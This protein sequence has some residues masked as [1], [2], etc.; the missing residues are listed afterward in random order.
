M[1][2]ESVI[3]NKYLIG[4]AWALA[5]SGLYLTSLHSYLLFHSLAEIFSIVVACAIFM[6]AWNSRKF[7]DNNYL[8]FIGI[9]YL[10]VGGLDLIHT[11]AYKG[12]NVLPGYGAN[13]PTQLWVATRYI[14]SLSLLIA[15][16]F[17][18]RKLRP[19][20]I[21]TGYSLVT[22][23]V[24]GTIFYWRIFPDCFIEGV[25][26]TPFKKISEYLISVIL[27]GSIAL[28]V[29]KQK[30]FDRHVLRL[31]IV[32]IFL[33]IA[34][35]LA[36]TFYVSVYGISNLFGHFFKIISFYLI[37]KAIIETGLTKPYDLLFRNL[38]QSEEAQR[39]ARDTLEQ[40]VEERAAE[41]RA[42]ESR[43]NAAQRMAQIGSWDRDLQKNKIYWSDEQYRIWGYEPGE[44]APSHE[45]V[46][47]HIYPD[48]LKI[49]DKAHETISY[50]K[51]PYDL[52][53]RIIRK[54]GA[55]R[56]VHSIAEGEWDEAGK[57]LRHFG[58]LQ[59][60]SKR[61]TVAEELAQQMQIEMLG[62]EIGMALARG[63]TLR[64]LLQPCAEAIVK[65]LDAVFARIWTFNEAEDMLELQASA[66]LYTRIDGS[67]SRVV[68]GE[69]KIG[70]IAQRLQPVI[71]NSV[72]GD[73]LFIDQEWAE[74]EGMVAFAGHPL[75]TGGRLMG[76]VAI[77]ASK[78]LADTTLK[79]LASVS[80]QFALGVRR[81]WAEEALRKSE[82]E[83][84]FLSSELLNA[85]ESERA[86]IARELHDG[87]GQALSTIKVRLETLLRIAR[88]DASQITV[89]NLENLVPMIRQT[90]EEVR[91]TSMDL[92]PSTLDG[93]GILPTID[94]FSREFQTTYPFIQI[95]KKIDI[96]ETDVPESLKIVIYRIVQEA[97]NNAANH[98]G[99][100]VM[101]I[102]LAKAEGE[103][104]LAV[105]DN[106]RGFDLEH[107]LALEDSRRGFGLTSM[108]ERAELSG[109]SF[110]IDASIG[111]GTT[112][113][114]TWK[115]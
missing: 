88:A 64:T 70:I 111:K 7:L 113:R 18:G 40:R 104:R 55:I 90:I 25:G 27:A 22:A 87:I 71:T 107:T 83:L 8:L 102:S 89:E 96:R 33:T 9:S 61:K 80:D 66:G 11:L 92:R 49:Y 4:L 62:A 20:L 57:P 85:Q 30:A 41:L 15:P 51:D 91:N 94:W 82:K 17:I 36:F 99:A 28:L 3:P 76:V 74:R 50:R 84:R 105:Q 19:N 79:A 93:L 53:Y 73:P 60:I 38:K 75:V 110:S 26:L 2:N 10:F 44:V 23:M 59:D 77:F 100:D 13:A 56:T 47:S 108:K 72:I 37:Y 24:L 95:E 34:A 14:E 39:K 5:L 12:M 78:P 115:V 48:D 65:H 31:L 45:L 21:V 35:E 81:Q 42:S 106:G 101:Q 29:R 114:A 46:R 43:L 97:L 6:V 112:I 54:D 86:R 109:G 58:C 69:S 98:S 52:E 67:R 1:K 68:L 32:S 63:D 16:V 103:I